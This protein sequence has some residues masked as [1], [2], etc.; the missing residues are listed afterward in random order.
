MVHMRHGASLLYPPGE[1]AL[2]GRHGLRWQ[3]DLTQSVLAQAC[4]KHD[5][6]PYRLELSPT[7]RPFLPQTMHALSDMSTAWGL[8][9][10]I[11]AKATTQIVCQGCTLT[12]P[13]RPSPRDWHMPV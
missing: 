9:M 12:L 7:K 11:W 10:C 2:R 8:T 1:E 5:N 4:Q 6:G 3:T 13:D